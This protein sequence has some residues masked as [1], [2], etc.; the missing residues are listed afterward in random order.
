MKIK[1]S[2]FASGFLGKFFTIGKGV[3]GSN[4]WKS[5]VSFWKENSLRKG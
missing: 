3:S 1:E 5:G 2:C 4:N